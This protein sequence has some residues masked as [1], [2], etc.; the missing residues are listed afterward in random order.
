MGICC[1]SKREHVNLGN[2]DDFKKLVDKERDHVEG[3]VKNLIKE[4]QSENLAYLMRLQKITSLLTQLHRKI[5]E[6]KDDIESD[7]NM[8]KTTVHEILDICFDMKEKHFKSKSDEFD[9]YDTNHSDNYLNSFEAKVN[10][11]LNNETK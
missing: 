8:T 2:A 4:S 11:Y 9:N 5:H 1:F 10:E 7:K 6:N 3:L